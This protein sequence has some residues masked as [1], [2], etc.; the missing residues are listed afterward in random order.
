MQELKESGGMEVKVEEEGVCREGIRVHPQPTVDPLDPLNWSTLQKN[1]ILG[2]VMFKYASYFISLITYSSLLLLYHAYIS[3]ALVVI[4]SFP[5]FI[6]SAQLL[7]SFKRY[8]LFT[9]LT[10]DTVPTFPE[11]QGI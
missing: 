11:L 9:Y 8:F 3:L 5:L 6:K 7:I 2:I 4:F 1:A 10:T